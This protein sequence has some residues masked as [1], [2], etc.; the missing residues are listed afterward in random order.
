MTWDYLISNTVGLTIAANALFF[1]VLTAPSLMWFFGTLPF[2][3]LGRISFMIFLLHTLV[4]EWMQD[5][6]VGSKIDPEDPSSYSNGVL[7]AFL[8]F[9]P[10]LILLATLF[11]YLVDSPLQELVHMINDAVSYLP[12]RKRLAKL[13]AEKNEKRDT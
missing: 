5:S 13:E 7:Y 4:I 2:S 11:Y 1:L 6:Y 8:I 12:N 3:F 9:T 10:V